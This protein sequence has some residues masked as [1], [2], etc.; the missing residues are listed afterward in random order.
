MKKFSYEEDNQKRLVKVAT[1]VQGLET[2]LRH[3]ICVA[4]GP[5]WGQEVTGENIFKLSRGQTVRLGKNGQLWISH[6]VH[7]VRVFQTLTGGSEFTI[8][9]RLSSFLPQESCRPEWPKA[10]IDSVIRGDTCPGKK[11]R[12]G[13][14]KSKSV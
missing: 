11:R 7:G 8:R 14:S 5:S 2:Y 6:C 1:A 13:G 9:M 4:V 10:W 3:G 12:S